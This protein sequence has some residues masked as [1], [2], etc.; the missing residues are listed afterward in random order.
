M[1]VWIAALAFA[2]EPKEI[3]LQPAQSP[4]GIGVGVML[5]EATGLHAAYRPKEGLSAQAGAG[6]S[7][8]HD[9]FQTHADLQVP[10]A[11]LKPGD[12]TT[13]EI[14]IYLGGGAQLEIGDS[15]QRRADPLGFALRGSATVVVRDKELPFD[16]F[17][18]VAPVAY[19]W[20][21]RNPLLGIDLDVHAGVHVFF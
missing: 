13:L 10:V 4:H 15:S 20:A 16:A 19:L 3:T 17:L 21:E 14:P 5:G 12:D 18:D 6:W 2:A 1:L 11:I 8:V 9:M 7:F